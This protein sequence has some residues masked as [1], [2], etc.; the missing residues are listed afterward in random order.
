M[1]QA[2]L[3]TK[4]FIPSAKPGLVVRQRLLQRLN[5]GLQRG[6]RLTLISAPA[7][8]GKST[9]IVEWIHAARGARPSAPSPATQFCWLTLDERDNDPARFLRYF[10]AALQSAGSDLGQE[11]LGL[12]ELPGQPPYDAC[13]AILVND[14]A[15][16]P[17]SVALV[18]DDY[19]TINT[20][21]VHQWIDALLESLPPNFHLVITTRTDPLLHLSRLRSRGQVT[22]IRSEDL[23]FSAEEAALFLRETMG[24]ALEESEVAVLQ[25]H[26]EGWAAGLQLAALS[27]EGACN[28]AERIH[29]F[30]AED[31]YVMDYLVEEVLCCQ[32]DEVQQ[33]LLK[34]SVLDRFCLDL[35]EALLEAPQPTLEGG[36]P[37]LE[38]LDRSNLFIQPIDGERRW[39]RYHSLFAE[40]LRQRL[41][42]QFGKAECDRLRLK[43]SAWC[44]QNEL[45]A[46]AIDYAMEAGEHGRL[47]DLL[48]QYGIQIMQQTARGLPQRWLNALDAGAH[49]RPMICAMDAYCEYFDNPDPSGQL[50]RKLEAL[51]RALAAET[52]PR[53]AQGRPLGSLVL[54]H[55]YALHAAVARI[56]GADSEE[57]LALATEAL[58]LLPEGAEL[59]RFESWRALYSTYLMRGEAALAEPYIVDAARRARAS[60]DEYRFY[61]VVFSQAQQAMYQ[62]KPL[63]AE[64]ICREALQERGVTAEK[65]SWRSM[66][67]GALHLMLGGVAME[68]GDFTS[69]E[70]FIGNGLERIAYY[71]EMFLKMRAWA[72]LA[73]IHWLRDEIGQAEENFKRSRKTWPGA[74]RYVDAQEVR[75]GL[76]RG[77]P[78]DLAQ[79]SAWASA[80]A[81]DLSD[82]QRMRS[83]LLEG[84]WHFVDQATLMRVLIARDRGGE[85]VDRGALSQALGLQQQIARECGWGARSL[86]LAILDALA[87]QAAGDT[88]R[89][90]AALQRALTQAEPQGFLRTFLDEGEPLRALLWEYRSFAAQ[91]ARRSLLAYLDQL[92]ER[93]PASARERMPAPVPAKRPQPGLIEPLSERELEVLRLVAE[94]LSNGEIARK[95]YLSPNT[96]KAHT[97]SIYGKLDVHSRVQ[98]VNLARELGLLAEQ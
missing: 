74:E 26:T 35:C 83:V 67:A 55:R 7:G 65:R 57:I 78:Q 16:Y 60:R 22:E 20:V 69:A 82:T 75:L 85:T 76:L 21:P 38:Y 96:L 1:L 68:R 70:E 36:V 73:R 91:T 9:L 50:E 45:V 88:D 49:Q 66:G 29:A 64:R 34:T 81:L 80:H 90:Y 23:R 25:E 6:S 86:E 93:F 97:Q 32:P 44:E 24:L 58:R 79:A 15:A 2:V 94:G 28:P 19:H 30:G 95:L 92:L 14:L 41:I 17:G 48:E 87:C 3:A 53:D 5:L 12:L 33:F 54:G 42:H 89:A 46:E 10:I 39:Y 84:E 62:G 52:D 8:Y 11:A 59:A 4:V 61:S 71:H 13:L 72:W 56:R 18:L 37:I 51:D 47:V 98:A 31:R 43:A 77:E 63:E 27:L 40:L